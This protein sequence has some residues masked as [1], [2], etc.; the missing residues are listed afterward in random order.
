MGDR[1]HVDLR[2]DER[3]RRLLLATADLSAERSGDGTYRTNSTFAITAVNCLDHPGIADEE[4]VAQDG[5]TTGRGVPDL[6]ARCRRGQLR[7][8]AGASAAG[9]SADHGRGRRSNRGDRHHRDPATPYPWAE[10]LAEQLDDG[11]LLTFEGNGHTAYGR[12][13]GCI[14]EQVDAYLLDG[15][16]PEDGLTC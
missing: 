3:G 7:P 6:R 14:E 10:S 9:A 12:S 11:V 2:C 13:G 8:L 4:W 15:T 5:R 16:M 1:T